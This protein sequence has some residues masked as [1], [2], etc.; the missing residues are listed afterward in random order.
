MNRRSTDDN[1][2]AGAAAAGRSGSAGDDRYGPLGPGHETATDPLASGTWVMSGALVMEAIVVLLA[3]TVVLRVDEGAYATP[4]NI[5][6]VAVL[7]VAMLLMSGLQ[8]RRWATPVNV[9]LQVLAV[10]G[11]IVHP[12]IGIAGVI[13]AAAWVYVY[14]LR[15]TIRERQRR[16]LL[17]A[18]HWPTE[19]RDDAGE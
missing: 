4:F 15:H 19:R 14:Y 1:G 6:Y 12:A 10:A 2:T 5:T 13:F 18:Q 17:P 16:G 9:I 8:K 3:L 11:F 7:G